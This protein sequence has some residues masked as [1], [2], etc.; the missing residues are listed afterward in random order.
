M[1]LIIF[2][3]GGGGVISITLFFVEGFYVILNK[4]SFL[5]Y[6]FVQ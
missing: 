6:I 5:S 1:C 4:V 2:G 3:E